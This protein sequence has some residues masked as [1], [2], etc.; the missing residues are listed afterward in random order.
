MQKSKYSSGDYSLIF[1]AINDQVC[2]LCLTRHCDGI[3]YAYAEVSVGGVAK[4]LDVE[5]VV[6]AQLFSKTLDSN[7]HMIC[8][9]KNC[10]VS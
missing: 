3:L 1:F 8:Q 5:L 9:S 4:S 6:E 10:C 7:G 2:K